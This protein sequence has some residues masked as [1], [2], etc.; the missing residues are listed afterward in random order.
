MQEIIFQFLQSIP[1]GTAIGVTGRAIT[2]LPRYV[3]DGTFGD[4]ADVTLYGCRQKEIDS[5]L[6]G[7]A[8]GGL[9]RVK[10]AAFDCIKRCLAVAAVTDVARVAALASALQRFDD[11][12]L[13]QLRLRTTV[14]LQQIHVTGF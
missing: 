7:N 10:V 14:E 9:Q 2:I 8:D 6:I 13:A 4:D 11:V 3:G 1:V 12:A 5:F